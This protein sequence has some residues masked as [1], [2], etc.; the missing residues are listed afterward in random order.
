MSSPALN[1]SKAGMDQAV[2]HFRKE[3]SNLRSGRANPGILDS[4]RVDVYGSEMR[5]KDLATIT[6]PEA[7]MILITPYDGQTAGAI[8]KGI[9]KANLNLQPIL[10]GKVIRI[11][12]PPL[13]EEL[14]KD[15][16][17][18]AKKKAEE[19]KVVIREHRRKGN[20]LLKQMKTAGDISEDDVKGIEKK[21]QE[22]TDKYCKDIDTMLTDKE[23]EIMTV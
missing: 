17:K 1:Q 12:I 3:M 11:S 18:Q 20:D 21:I 2:D 9:E 5:I 14:R 8:S 4:V 22:L 19:T 23:K 13:N 7:R 10:E 6:M 15:I 16:C